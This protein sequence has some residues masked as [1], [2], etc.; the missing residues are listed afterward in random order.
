MR[1]VYEPPLS[2]G[3]MGFKIEL[4]TQTGMHKNVV[5]VMYRVT[6][7]ADNQCRDQG[8]QGSPA[9]LPMPV[10]SLRNR[11]T[12]TKSPWPGQNKKTSPHKN[13]RI[14]NLQTK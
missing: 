5:G 13:A 2:G 3:G 8:H 4:L 9:K 6:A 7:N 1:A 10:C 14:K 11:L 12:C